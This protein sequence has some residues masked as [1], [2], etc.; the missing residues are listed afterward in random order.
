MGIFD[1]FKKSSDEIR[2]VQVNLLDPNLGHTKHVWTIGEQ[3]D[4]ETVNKF[5]E[6]GNLYVSVAYLDGEPKMT[7][8]KKPMWEELKTILGSMDQDANSSPVLRMLAEFEAE[9]KK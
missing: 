8:C 6:D 9:M 2:T 7:V 5:S 4:R 3:I 1:I